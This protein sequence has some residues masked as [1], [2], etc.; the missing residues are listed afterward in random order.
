MPLADAVRWNERYL[1]SDRHTFSSARALL[2]DHANLLPANG[3]ALDLAMGLGG[4]SGFLLDRGLSVVGVDIAS[5]A[6]GKAKKDYPKV[7]A[8]IADLTDFQFP[9]ATFDVICNFFYLDRQA[10]ANIGAWL[11]PGGLLFYETLTEEMRQLDPTINPIHLLKPNE[12]KIAFP[13]FTILFYAEGWYGDHHPRATA[14]LIA[15]KTK[16]GFEVTA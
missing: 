8:V 14:R 11:K 4:S 9:P 3:L 2:T 5:V 6:I 10:W 1:T 13:D 15:Q 16:N 12:L 7:M